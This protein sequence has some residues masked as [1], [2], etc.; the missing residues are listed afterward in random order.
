MEI[1][2]IEEKENGLF[3]R[4][5]IKG[6]VVSEVTPSRTEI[7]AVLAKKFSTPEENVKI[8][9]IHGKFGSKTFEVTANIY[10]S[11]EE[12]DIVEIKK[13]KESEAEKKMAE[14]S[15]PKSE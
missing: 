4:K 9:G 6:E 3:G 7:L 2:I 5:E 13:K 15:A 8:R 11:R 1:K 14:A 10:S 12:K